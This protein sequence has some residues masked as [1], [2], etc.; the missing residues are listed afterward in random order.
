MEGDGV[1]I[2]I[3]GMTTTET[4]VSH[5]IKPKPKHLSIAGRID[6]ATVF[7][8]KGTF[9]RAVE[10]GKEGKTFIKH[11][12][13]DM[14]VPGVAKEFQGKQRVHRMAGRDHLAARETS[15]LQELI[16]ANLHE[17]GQEKKEAAKAGMKFSW[18]EVQLTYVRDRRH[19]DDHLLLLRIDAHDR[20]ITPGEARSLF[21]DVLELLV[22][23][24]AGAL[25]DLL[26]VDA[27]GEVEILEDPGHRLWTDLDVQRLEFLGDLPGR[28]SRPLGSGAWVAGDVV[29]HQLLDP[30]DHLRS[31][32]PQV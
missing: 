15:V 19:L 25:G 32:F 2:E 6:P 22:S 23:I 17:I 12:G 1:E 3:K 7:G 24:R 11:I 30:R 14:T 4:K 28:T 5:G 26:V 27:Q 8:E 20:Q 16:E 29:L 21:G 10:S 13:H 9:G 31:F 18:C